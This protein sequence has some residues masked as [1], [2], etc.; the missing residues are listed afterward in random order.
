MATPV[1]NVMGEVQAILS[2]VDLLYDL[3]DVVGMDFRVFDYHKV[4]DDVDPESRCVFMTISMSKYFNDCG[5]IVID[6]ENIVDYESANR[7]TIT[8]H[9]HYVNNIF[10]TQY[11]SHDRNDLK[12]AIVSLFYDNRMIVPS[13]LEVTFKDKPVMFFEQPEYE[14]IRSTYVDIVFRSH[15]ASV[16]SRQ[17]KAIS[18]DP[19]TKLGKKL[20]M[21]K[22]QEM[23]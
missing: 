6:I 13:Y 17:W 12:H 14:Q 8:L 18:S 10:R 3:R 16:I 21:K 2:T 4:P 23:Q 9:N 11:T 5:Q 1:K 19:N 7:R 15:A 22:F 20:I